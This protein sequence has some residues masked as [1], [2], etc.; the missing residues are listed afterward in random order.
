MS[1]IGPSSPIGG[2]KGNRIF[3]GRNPRSYR[4]DWITLIDGQL[5]GSGYA[6]GA[7]SSGGVTFSYTSSLFSPA[8]LSQGSIEYMEK[9]VVRGVYPHPLYPDHPY[10]ANSPSCEDTSQVSDTIAYTIRMTILPD[11]KSGTEERTM[12]MARP[13]VS[14]LDLP[15][16]QL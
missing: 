12:K 13:S 15:V 14:L 2:Y 7:S 4:F 3:H 10:H 9:W 5:V 6:S 16:L 1:G 8:A 11:P